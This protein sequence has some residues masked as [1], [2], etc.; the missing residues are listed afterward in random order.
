MYY[1]SH[2]CLTVVGDDFMAINEPKM[3]DPAMVPRVC[4][5]TVILSDDLLEN[6]EFF[7]FSISNPLQD[8]GLNLSDSSATVFITDTSCK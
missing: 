1:L 2:L 3:F 6:T 8:T 7:T 5:M 4:S